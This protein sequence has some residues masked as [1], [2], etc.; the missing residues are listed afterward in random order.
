MAFFFNAD[1]FSVDEDG[2]GGDDYILV[3]FDVDLD[4]DV[5][6]GVTV[7]AILYDHADKIVAT[8]E[9]S[10]QVTGQ[11]VGYTSLNLIPSPNVEGV[12]YIHIALSDLSDELYIDDIH[13]SP[14]PGSEPVAYFADVM[15]TSEIDDIKVELDVNILQ[16]I[17][18]DITA[19]AKLMDSVGGLVASR[20]LHYETFF[21]DIDYQHLVF[22]PP[23]E[24][25]YSVILL[26]SS[27]E[28][29]ITTD[30]RLLQ[31]LWPPGTGAYFSKYETT[32]FDDHIEVTFDVNLA[33]SIT[34]AVSVEAILYDSSSD[35]VGYNYVS[36]MT[37]GSSED[38]RTLSLVPEQTI[39]DT[40][41]AELIVYTDGYPASYGYIEEIRYGQQ[42][43]DING[44][45]V[46]DLVDLLI[47]SINFGRKTSQLE[48]PNADINSDGI[49]DM[50]DLVILG[51]H[52][53]ENWTIRD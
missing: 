38:G 2:D 24:D 15:V 12:Y 19:E 51:T 48:N 7:I 47:L 22:T 16:Q 33:Y 8:G 20:T 49:V 45:N 29:G 37:N 3:Q 31:S 14:E 53:G 27:E 21:D 40:Y 43:W 35:V 17:V 18:W 4:E 25:A 34:Y 32:T 42:R 36:Y 52:Y 26:V 11:E 28:S 39:A 44:D 41:Y 13:Y 30:S 46:V 50:R 23:G 5:T 1:A 6:S 10:Y 9:I